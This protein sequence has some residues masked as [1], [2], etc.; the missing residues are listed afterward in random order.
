MLAGVKLDMADGGVTVAGT[1]RFRLSVAHVPAVTVATETTAGEPSWPGALLRKFPQAPARR[2]VAY[3]LATRW[4]T[5]P[6]PR[7]THHRAPDG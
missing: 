5:T 4:S 3:R 1:D 2:P 6:A 7:R